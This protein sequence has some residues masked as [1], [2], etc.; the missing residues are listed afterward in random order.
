MQIILESNVISINKG[1]RLLSI[2]FNSKLLALLIFCISL[3][4]R[5]INILRPERKKT[6]DPFFRK[7]DFNFLLHYDLIPDK[8]I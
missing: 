8:D 4:V 2:E 7:V 3:L 5:I 6:L 1:A